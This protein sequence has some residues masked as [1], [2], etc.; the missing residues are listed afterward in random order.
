MPISTI[1]IVNYF[2]IKFYCVPL[3]PK[4]LKIFKNKLWQHNHNHYKIS[5]HHFA[6]LICIWQFLINEKLF[7]FKDFLCNVCFVIFNNVFYGSR[8]FTRSVIKLFINFYKFFS[9]FYQIS[10]L[11]TLHKTSLAVF[12]SLIVH[13]ARFS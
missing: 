11:L 9:D 10:I 4:C 5:L 12:M 3:Y 7:I 8:I 13:I 6:F 1:T 2:C